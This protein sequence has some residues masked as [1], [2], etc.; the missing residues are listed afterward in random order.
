MIAIRAAAFGLLLSL[1]GAQASPARAQPPA[2]DA[3]KPAPVGTAMLAGTIVVDDAEARPL[4]RVRV[5]IMTSDRQTSRTAITDDAGRFSFTALPAG[6]ML[7]ASRQGHVNASY[8]ARRP[9]RPG[10]A[11]VLAEG[12]R[13]TGLNLRMARGG[14]IS[15]GTC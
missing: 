3:A 2:R 15:G 4:R 10:T 12:Q 13:I 8:G 6:R 1:G 7:N 11:L 9:N 14:V 5:G